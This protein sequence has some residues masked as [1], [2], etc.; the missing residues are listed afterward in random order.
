VLGGL[1]R[2]DARPRRS[3]AIPRLRLPG[4]ARALHNPARRRSESLASSPRRTPIEPWRLVA[5]AALAFALPRTPPSAPLTPRATIAHYNGATGT[6]VPLWDLT[7]GDVPTVVVAPAC[8]APAAFGPTTGNADNAKAVG[9][10]QWGPILNLGTC[11][12]GPGMALIRLRVSCV[13]GPTFTLPGGCLGQVLQASV[14]LGAV[15]APHNGVICNVPNQAVPLSA[16][17]AP[18]AAQATVSEFGTTRRELSS[19]IYGVVDA[20]F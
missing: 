16:I 18:W 1:P 10:Q 3:P 2:G 11:V 7:N 15:N 9:G 8:P 6:N 13:N 5:A 19:V 4:N 12:T 17:G 14:L 20:C